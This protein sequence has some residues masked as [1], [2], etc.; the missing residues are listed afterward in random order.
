M[1]AV[2]AFLV[3]IAAAAV[4]VVD[5]AG[6]ASWNAN[7]F[8]L[9]NAALSAN[10]YANATSALDMDPNVNGGKTLATVNVGDT[11]SFINL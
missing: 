3:N 2:S 9:Y 11:I 8:I 5:N 10:M 1:L 7:F 6:P 4:L